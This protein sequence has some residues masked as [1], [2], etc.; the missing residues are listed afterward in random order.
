MSRA[1]YRTAE[2]LERREVLYLLDADTLI[3][4]DNL[5]YPPKAFPVFWPWLV[6]MGACHTIKIP[7]EQYEEITNGTGGLVDWLKDDEVKGALIFAEEANPAIVGEV[8]LNG[9]GELD[10]NGLE[11]VGKDP[12]LI[13]HGYA[14]KAQRTIVTFE[15][16]AP[17]KKGANRKI[18]DV[19]GDL[20]VLSCNLFGLI[21]AL[22]F[23]TDWKPK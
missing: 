16:S 22:N 7:Q 10:E 17:S 12:F 21:K 20:G 3:R 13:S 4:A 2:R 19:C 18:P 5:Y 23:T 8:T 15:V 6:H 14:E 9:Y 11:K 1:S